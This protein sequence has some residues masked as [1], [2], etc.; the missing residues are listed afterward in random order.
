MKRKSVLGIIFLLI[1][2]VGA[3]YYF[4]ES[5]PKL[6]AVETNQFSKEIIKEF[7]QYFVDQHGDKPWYGNLSKSEVTVNEKGEV[8]LKLSSK[9]FVK[10][11]DEGAVLDAALGYFSEPV[12]EKYK[13]KNVKAQVINP[14]HKLIEEKSAP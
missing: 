7:N 8:L 11:G 10:S 6:T 12:R 1:L 9:D 5:S 3:A 4:F 14:D 13:V 2:G